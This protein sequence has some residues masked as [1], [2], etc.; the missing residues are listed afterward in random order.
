[1]GIGCGQDKNS[2]NLAKLSHYTVIGQLIYQAPKAIADIK[3]ALPKLSAD[4]KSDA[5][6]IED[7]GD[8][9]KQGIASA[10]EKQLSNHAMETSLKKRHVK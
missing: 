5:H 2:S 3:K 1:M 9:A 6:K 4:I 10:R 8:S 7:A